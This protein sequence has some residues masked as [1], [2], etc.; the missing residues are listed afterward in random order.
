MRE[1]RQRKTT[2]ISTETNRFERGR[3]SS[4]RSRLQEMDFAYSGHPGKAFSNAFIYRKL[5]L[6]VFFPGDGLSSSLISAPTPLSC[7][8][9]KSPSVS[10][11]KRPAIDDSCIVSC[12]ATAPHPRVRRP[13]GGE[14]RLDDRKFSSLRVVVGSAG[15]P[16][17]LGGTT[18]NTG[19]NPSTVSFDPSTRQI[20]TGRALINPFD[21]S[22][23]TIKLTSNRR[24]WTHIFPKGDLLQ[25]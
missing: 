15:S 1:T 2:A 4:R 17:A 23:V 12:G 19:A 21:P 8:L 24:R 9:T 20:K 13:S 11:P 10:I 3:G 6:T 14:E 22:R 25:P 5:Q 7:S 18:A 16:C